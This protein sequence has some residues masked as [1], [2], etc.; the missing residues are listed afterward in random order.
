MNDEFQD[1]ASSIFGKLPSEYVTP[2]GHLTA[3]GQEGELRHAEAEIRSGRFKLL[4]GKTAHN[5]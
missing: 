2:E 1:N 3:E 5:F 4:A